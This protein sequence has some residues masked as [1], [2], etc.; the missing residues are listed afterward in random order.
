MTKLWL[1]DDDY[2]VINEERI[3]KDEIRYS[4]RKVKGGD[5]K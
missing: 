3:S 2:E 5:E 1:W 4:I